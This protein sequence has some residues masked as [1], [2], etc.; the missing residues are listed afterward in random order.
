MAHHVQQAVHDGVDLG[1][2]LED[3]RLDRRPGRRQRLLQGG[4][5]LDPAHLAKDLRDRPPR[6]H[7]TVGEAPPATGRDPV[8]GLQDLGELLGESG[9]AHTGLS[10]QQHQLRPAVADR[11]ASS[12]E[13]H[14]E[15]DG[16]THQGTR[17]AAPVTSGRAKRADRRPHLL[18]L[19]PATR[20]QVTARL[21][22][23][24]LR[25]GTMGRLAHH[26]L[27]GSGRRL[28]PG[29][30]VHHVAHRGVV[31]AGPQR[32]D[33]HLAGVDPDP[34]ADVDARLP[35]ER[36]EGLL[37]PHGRPDGPLGIVLVGQRCAEQ[38]EDGVADDLV[39]PPTEGGDVGD[40][41]LEGRID[42]PLH[43]FRVATLR[44]GGETDQIGEEH[45]DDPAFLRP[46][47]QGVPA[48]R[49]EPG[50]LLDDRST[51]RA[52]HPASIR[53]DVAGS[54][55]AVPGGTGTGAIAT[56]AGR[57]TP[58]TLDPWR[59]GGPRRDGRPRG[60]HRGTRG[61]PGGDTGSGRTTTPSLGR[62]LRGRSSPAQPDHQRR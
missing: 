2:I 13:E 46:A 58:R 21:V 35:A 30:Q 34:H 20:G 55:C 56:C 4:V 41:A 25:S 19:L 31:A 17:R 48:V 6:V 14:A 49:A 59:D 8:L 12:V 61:R 32:T 22:G 15:L 27:P 43:R 33:E 54:G 53:P 9:L 60:R 62:A 57:H 45:G 47:R 10:H 3:H 23:D 16:S 26:H 42:D 52:L 5:P 18:G 7:L 38:R 1:G 36:C 29:R 44:E 28:Q 11:A 40:E 51:A 39:D 37:H 50:V 24:G